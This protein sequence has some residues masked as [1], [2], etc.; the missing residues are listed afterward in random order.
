MNLRS[1]AVASTF[2]VAMLLAV[3]GCTTNA[4]HAEPH[5]DGPVTPST[6][7]TGPSVDGPAT[8]S[9]G[10]TEAGPL[11]VGDKWVWSD[12]ESAGSATVLGYEQ[13]VAKDA[14]TPEEDFGSE[15]KGYVWAALEVKV[16]VTKADGVETTVSTAP[17][18]IAYEDGA[19]IR[20]TNDLGDEAPRPQYPEDDTLVRPGDCIRGKTVFAVPGDKWPERAL[21]VPE[22]SEPAEWLLKKQ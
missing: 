15:A 11:M 5:A 9:T 16:C 6:R 1:A 19:R 17:W 7:H 12:E 4:N 3:S 18:S 10:P 13:D 20:P 8:P 2:S 14:W 22:S 21:Y